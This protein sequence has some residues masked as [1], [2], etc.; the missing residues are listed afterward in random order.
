MNLDG[1][2][3]YIQ[4]VARSR[5][6]NN[7]TERHVYDYGEGIELI[8]VAGE[9]VA[10]RFLGCEEKVHDRFDNGVDIYFLDYTIDVKA[11][12]LTPRVEFRFLQWPVWK[13]VKSDIIMLTAIDPIRKIGTVIGYATKREIVA[14]PVNQTRANPCH[15]I[16]AKDLHPA[17]LLMEDLVRSD[18]GK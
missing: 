6:A 16:S 2:W 12:V 8:G 3:P 11:T 9:I 5:L 4:N 7:K 17:W 10:R 15:E 14:A 13:T 18:V 1:S